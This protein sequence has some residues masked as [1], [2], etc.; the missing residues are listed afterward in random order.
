MDSRF[1]KQHLRSFK[2]LYR[3][4]PVQGPVGHSLLSYLEHAKALGHVTK[5]PGK[6][7]QLNR[8]IDRTEL[9][10]LCATGNHRLFCFC[11]I[12]AW[13]MRKNH[14]RKWKDFDA[15]LKDVKLLPK[16]K[17]VEAAPSRREAFDSLVSEGDNRVP[18]LG[19][20]FF[21]KLIFFFRRHGGL[22]SVHGTL[23]ILVSEPA[24]K[25]TSMTRE[26][27]RGI[28]C[29]RLVTHH[30]STFRKTTSLVGKSISWFGSHLRT[31]SRSLTRTIRPRELMGNTALVLLCFVIVSINMPAL[32]R[33]VPS[34][35]FVRVEPDVP[36]AT[37]RHT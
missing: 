21:T 31:T 1:H 36:V 35:S 9:R 22:Q 34:K 4:V 12:M 23:T 25:A 37:T 2:A 3:S 15:A 33:I 29:R 19:V 26:R 17:A 14:F 6:F 16:L 11:A 10:Q 20:A 28:R 8:K 27:R 5:P 7:G 30:F 24:P 13:G 18:G 32:T